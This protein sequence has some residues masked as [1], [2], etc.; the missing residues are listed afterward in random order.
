MESRIN[1]RTY[2]ILTVL[3]IAVFC[4]L[5]LGFVLSSPERLHNADQ[6]ELNMLVEAA[7]GS[8]FYF[9]DFNYP[10][11]HLQGRYANIVLIR[12]L[13]KVVG[14][15]YLNLKLFALILALCALLLWMWSLKTVFG[16]AVALCF[17]LLMTFPP[18]LFFKWSM[19][20]WGA[21]PE[22]AFWVALVFALIVKA[23]FSRGKVKWGWTILL[24][25]VCGLA[26]SY[27][28]M[29]VT[30]P[31]L[32][33]LAFLANGKIRF[34]E[35]MIRIVSILIGLRLGLIPLFQY[36][37]HHNDKGLS[38]HPDL[39]QNSS[40]CMDVFSQFTIH[41]DTSESFWIFLLRIFSELF[42]HSLIV[43]FMV[44]V[45]LLIF[46]MSSTVKKPPI[47]FL[48]PVAVM[49][50]PAIIAFSAIRQSFSYR[51]IMPFFPVLAGFIAVGICTPWDAF[52]RGIEVKFSH[53]IKTDRKQKERSK[54]KSARF[55]WAGP[56]WRG[57]MTLFCIWWCLSNLYALADF[58]KLDRLDRISRFRVIDYAKYD[59]GSA[60]GKELDALNSMIDSGR[61][62]DR[63]FAQGF[64]VAFP[65]KGHY[66]GFFSKPFFLDTKTVGKKLRSV[67][68]EK[69][70]MDLVAEGFGAGVALK[71]YERKQAEKYELLLP[72][73]NRKNYWDGFESAAL[74]FL[75]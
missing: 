51:H 52:Y 58:I 55:S 7:Q 5:R 65:I 42:N 45:C 8:L 49:M 9:K 69:G 18:L 44:V 53:L 54:P 3:I 31:V 12:L 61:L 57:M 21:Y 47:S 72:S 10:F 43:L 63:S 27:S 33:C 29:N 14:F 37:S 71:G 25:V 59:V 24:G 20:V 26:V 36:M 28:V 2:W 46:A 74:R 50:L 75:E 1:N 67:S 19:I 4:F 23:S 16:P 73:A 32:A 64:A 66:D 60:V 56:I 11:T 30:L 38:L 48:M 70:E 17:A 68:T 13:A 35:R 62:N 15:N 39:T 22:S 41:A 40:Q 34:K 6:A